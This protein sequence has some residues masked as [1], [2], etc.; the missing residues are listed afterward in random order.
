MFFSFAFAPLFGYPVVLTLLHSG[1]M[2]PST[3]LPPVLSSPLAI[4]II[5]ATLATATPRFSTAPPTPPRASC[6]VSPGLRRPPPMS[7]SVLRRTS[8]GRSGTHP[9]RTVWAA[10]AA[11]TRTLWTSKARRAAAWP[12]GLMLP[13]DGRVLDQRR[14]EAATLV[15]YSKPS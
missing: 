5:S 3:P 1:V 13:V 2:H 11:A 4:S 15:E 6:L 8:T 14:N 7:A 9:R 10:A 12:S